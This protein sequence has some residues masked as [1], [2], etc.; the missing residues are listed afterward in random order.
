MVGRQEIQKE[1]W[2][3]RMHGRSILLIFFAFL[4]INSC[5]N[6]NQIKII[7][8]KMIDS[9]NCLWR[10]N[11]S[12]LF[13][14]HLNSTKQNL[15]NIQ[16]GAYRQIFLLNQDTL[17][18]TLGDSYADSSYNRLDVYLNS[19]KINFPQKFL[20]DQ[21][22]QPYEVY[23]IIG[24]KNFFVISVPHYFNGIGLAYT[25]D[26]FFDLATKKIITLNLWFNERG[27]FGDVNNN[28]KLDILQ[29]NQVDDLASMKADSKYRQH[30][31]WNVYDAEIIE[32]NEDGSIDTIPSKVRNSLYIVNTGSCDFWEIK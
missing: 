32:L 9:D 14:I 21:F 12:D 22:S 8:D 10:N 11:F 7:E 18:L 29:F 6:E 25:E 27:I 5:K 20:Y 4:L 15:I 16:R 19:E 17:T 3:L 24:F 30:K 23:A 13:D 26:Y 1:L 31:T 28:G 2:E